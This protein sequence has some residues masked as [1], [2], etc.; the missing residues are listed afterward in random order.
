[1]NGSLKD[2]RFLLQHLKFQF[3][4]VP[5]LWFEC[6]VTVRHAVTIRVPV[7]LAPCLKRFLSVWWHQGLNSG[8]HLCQPVASTRATPLAQMTNNILN[9]FLKIPD[10]IRNID[11]L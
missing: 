1:M 7:G 11:V 9:H 3:V 5:V 6:F 4:M 10:Y 2:L 8:S